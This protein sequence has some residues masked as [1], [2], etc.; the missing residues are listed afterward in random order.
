MMLEWVDVGFV[1]VGIGG[2]VSLCESVPV[3]LLLWLEIV[4]AGSCVCLASASLPANFF[5]F[6]CVQVDL[7]SARLRARVC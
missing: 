1:G 5:S 2:V 3:S 4:S 6:L 7:Y